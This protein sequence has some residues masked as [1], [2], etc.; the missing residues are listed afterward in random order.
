METV[1][2]YYGYPIIKTKVVD[3][4]IVVL[5]NLVKAENKFTAAAKMLDTLKRFVAA[6]HLKQTQPL[7]AQ[8]LPKANNSV[9]VNI[10]L[11]INAKA[12]TTN[13]ITYMIMPKNGNLYTAKF[14][15][16]FRDRDKVFNALHRYYNDHQIQL[17]LA[18]FEIYLNNQLPTNETSQVD[19][20]LNFT[21][22]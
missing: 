10:G 19:I 15:G 13:N 4:N 6:N 21:S 14:K 22:F 2:L 18:P 11:P 5:K 9:Q 7:M 3:T 17:P 12:K 1:S 16:Q 20:Q 8:F